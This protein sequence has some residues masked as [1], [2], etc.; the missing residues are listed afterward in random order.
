M[1]SRGNTW[2]LLGTDFFIYEVQHVQHI[3]IYDEKLWHGVSC[4]SLQRSMQLFFT[5]VDVIYII[6]V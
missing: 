1:N 6:S 3:K 2:D 5:G 4:T